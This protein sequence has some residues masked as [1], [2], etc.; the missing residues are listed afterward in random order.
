M[1]FIET[2]KKQTCNRKTNISMVTATK[3][4]QENPFRDFILKNAMITRQR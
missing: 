1:A 2:L 4:I 3:Y